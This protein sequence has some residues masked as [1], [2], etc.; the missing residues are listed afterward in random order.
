MIVEF[1]DQFLPF[2]FY[3]A[4]FY[5]FPFTKKMQIFLVSST[6]KTLPRHGVTISIFMTKK[7]LYIHMPI[8]TY[9]DRP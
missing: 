2:H 3:C 8:A 9:T 6:V 1:G 4:F 5:L 7:M